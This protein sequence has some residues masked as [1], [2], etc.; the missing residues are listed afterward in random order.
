MD[1]SQPRPQHKPANFAK[2]RSQLHPIAGLG[3]FSALMTATFVGHDRNRMVFVRCYV[4]EDVPDV[5]WLTRCTSMVN[6]NNGQVY[7]ATTSCSHNAT[8]IGIKI[9]AVPKQQSDIYI[10]SARQ[11][12]VV[13]TD[14]Q[15]FSPPQRCCLLLQAPFCLQP[16]T[17]TFLLMV[18]R[19]LNKVLGNNRK[20]THALLSLN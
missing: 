10:E 9:L 11:A 19:K 1:S 4:S 8:I 3:S 20:T 15:C 5:C 14:M 16:K 17:S 13:R 18:W 2:H 12:A 6:L 7:P